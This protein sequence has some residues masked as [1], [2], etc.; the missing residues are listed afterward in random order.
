MPYIQ[1]VILNISTGSHVIKRYTPCIHEE[2]S[3]DRVRPRGGS[4]GTRTAL[5]GA[6]E[7]SCVTIPTALEEF[8]EGDRYQGAV[9]SIPSPHPPRLPLDPNDPWSS[10]GPRRSSNSVIYKVC[11]QIC[12]SHL[13]P[14]IELLPEALTDVEVS[15]RTRSLSDTALNRVSLASSSP[16]SSTIHPPGKEPS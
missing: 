10:G 11:V 9:A 8:P 14:D 1:I 12:S 6:C 5:R 3:A 2:S 13:T 7:R 16:A 4:M 15:P